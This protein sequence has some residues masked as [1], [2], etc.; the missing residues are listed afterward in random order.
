MFLKKNCWEFMG[1]GDKA[2][3][4]SAFLDQRFDGIN[5]GKNGGRVC[6]AVAGTLCRESKTKDILV[7]Y[8][9]CIDCE[10]F[11]YVH[12]GEDK[13]FTI[14]EEVYKRGLIDPNNFGHL[15]KPE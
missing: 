7:K 6:W 14:F 13:K 15:V 10:F 4:C 1:C 3:S 11:S 12:Q 9:D 8:D 5:H 2:K